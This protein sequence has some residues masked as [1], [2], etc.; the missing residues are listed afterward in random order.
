MGGCDAQDHKML[1]QAMHLLEDE[2]VKA[3]RRK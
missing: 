3:K 2:L 1:G